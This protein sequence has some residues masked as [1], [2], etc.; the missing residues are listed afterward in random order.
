MESQLQRYARRLVEEQL[1]HS[2]LQLA[3][4]AD[5]ISTV[6]T[7]QDTKFGDDQK[8]HL[9]RYKIRLFGIHGADVEERALPWAY[10]KNST[11][12]LRG[13][14]TGTVTYPRGTFVYVTQDLQSNEYFIERVA[15]NTVKDLPL[16]AEQAYTPLSGFDPTNTLYPVPDTNFLDGAL[17]PG[18]EEYNVSFRSYMDYLQNSPRDEAKWQFPVLDGAKNTVGGMSSAI[19][20][21]IKDVERLKKNLIGSN[22][23]LRQSL[24]TLENAEKSVEAI[25]QA[26]SKQVKLISGYINT[27]M[28]KVQ[29][30]F[31]RKLNTAMNMVTANFPLSG[32]FA[33]NKLI[34]QAIKALS[35]AFNLSISEM[36]NLVG[37]GL[38]SVINKVVNTASC[39]IEN[40]VSNF[41]GQIVGQLSALINGVIGTISNVLGGAT[42]IL[43]SIG[44]VLGSIMD[45]LNCEVS[46]SQD[47]PVVK[48]WNFLDGGSPVKITLN[49]N[50]IFD[51]AK[52]IGEKFQKLTKVPKNISKY[53]FKFDPKEAVS[54]TLDQCDT[55]PIECGVPQVSFWGGTG[56]GAKANVA[57]S[58]TTG[59]VAHVDM[60]ESGSYTQAPYVSIVDI[61]GKGR[62]AVGKAILGPVETETTTFTSDFAGTIVSGTNYISG[63]NLLPDAPIQN[64]ID[65]VG[66]SIMQLSNSPSIPAG[67]KIIDVKGDKIILNK[68]IEGDGSV[69]DMQFHIIGFDPEEAVGITTFTVAVKKTPRTNKFVID[70]RQQR[71]VT[72]ERG[73]T[74]KFDQSRPSNGL[75]LEGGI[76]E[77]VLMKGED[78]FGEIS[79]GEYEEI[80]RHPLRFST[81]SD[82]I[83]NCDRSTEDAGPEDWLL[84]SS[85]ESMPAD[86]WV[87]TASD[88]WSPFLQAYGVYPEYEVLPGVHTGNWEIIL[89]EPGTYRVQ[90]QAD[91]LG[92]VSWNGIYLG[93]TDPIPT[94]IKTS[95]IFN[96]VPPVQQ[97]LNIVKLNKANIPVSQVIKE[98][99]KKLFLKD[100]DGNDANATFSIDSGDAIF[101]VKSTDPTQ[102]EI[103]G[104]GTVTLTLNWGDNPNIAGVALESITIGGTAWYQNG[105]SGRQ[106]ETIKLTE[107]EAGSYSEIT[108]SYKDLSRGPHNTPKYFEFEVF[109]K[110]KKHILTATI[111]NT[112]L[113]E[114]TNLEARRLDWE[115]NPGALAWEVTNIDGS[116]AYA[117]STQP[118]AEDPEAELTNCGTEYTQGITVF[119]VPGA[120]NAYI[121]FA[122]FPDAPDTLYYYCENHPKMGAKINIVDG[123]DEVD[124]D[125]GCR[126]ATLRVESLNEAGDVTLLSSLRGGSGYAAGA[127]NMLTVGGNGTS[128][129]INIMTVGDRGDIGLIQIANGGKNYQVGDI[130]TPVCN[131][132]TKVVKKEGIGVVR[133][134]L[135]STGYGY[136]PWP[137]GSKGGMERTWADRCQTI[138]HRDNGDWD[139]PYTTGEIIELYPGDCITL[140][141]KE[142]IC[143]DEDFDITKLPGS[144]LIGEVVTPRDMSDFPLSEYVE[145]EGDEINYEQTEK[146]EPELYVEPQFIPINIEYIGLNIT[147]INLTVTNNR[148]KILLRDGDGLDTNASFEIEEVNGGIAKFA[149]DGR[150]IVVQGA[151]VDVQ[152]AL[153]WKDD[154]DTAG[155]AIESI[156]IVGLNGP[157][158]WVRTGLRGI[159]RH[160]VFLSGDAK[161]TYVERVDGS[162]PDFPAGIAQWWF[163]MNGRYEGTF[164]QENLSQVPQLV[165]RSEKLIYRIGEYKEKRVISLTVDPKEWYRMVDV[166][167]PDN[168]CLTH[169]AGWSPFLKNYGVWP[170]KTETFDDI[171]Q[172]GTWE[173]LIKDAGNYYFEVQSDGQASINFNGR[174]LG[175]TSMFKSHNRSSFFEIEIK[176]DSLNKDDSYIP[177]PTP[178]TVEGTIINGRRNIGDPIEINPG[179]IAWVLRKGQA[180]LPAE[181]ITNTSFVDRDIVESQHNI[182]IIN[183]Y[184]PDSIRWINSKRIEFDE[185]PFYN[186]PGGW[187]INAI[188]TIDRVEG[189]TAVFNSNGKTIDCTGNSVTVTLTL[190][191]DDKRASDGFALDGIEI[192]T[193]RWNRSGLQGSDTKTVTLEGTV[194]GTEKIEIRNQFYPPDVTGTGDI[195]RSSLDPFQS[196]VEETESYTKSYYAINKYKIL[197]DG[198]DPEVPEIFGCEPDYT[199]AKL[200]GYSDCDIRHLIESLGIAVDQCM[201]NKLDDENWGKCAAFSVRLTAPDCP[202]KVIDSCPPGYYY[203]N[204]RCIRDTV[205]PG[206]C[207]PGYRKD[208]NGTCIPDGVTCPE[209]SHLE[210]GV[211]VPG[212]EPV[213]PVGFHKD[214]YGNCVPDDDTCPT[215]YKKE[216]GL[217]VP[218]VPTTCPSSSTYKIILCLDQITVANPGFGYNCCDDTVV[219]EPSNGA[220]AVIEECDGGI[221]RVR[222]TKCGSGFTE[223]PDVYINTKTGFNAFLIPVLK[224]HREN[225]NEF[226]EGTVVTQIIDCVGNVGP[227][228]KTEVT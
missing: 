213:C 96:E 112:G 167:P 12:G 145:N 54:N 8:T 77:L 209:G 191:Y 95:R 170:S 147:N 220:E 227:N 39:L 223:L 165:R 53:K 155:V 150:S 65:L 110:G 33:N 86:S 117:N 182:N 208:S 185:D 136:L 17:V 66:R 4:I 195:I 203:S 228:A 70:D 210:N 57:I 87:L 56:S 108:A 148:T 32:K 103:E 175:S 121:S 76:D 153:V 79:T 219:I 129:S 160:L 221:I 177:L 205:D 93:A 151:Y 157:K 85:L 222:V 134:E 186:G 114:L 199:N 37:Q 137:D 188:F 159:E 164:I 181:L 166:L 63:F 60:E 161:G 41:V 119:G 23:A 35:C 21:A 218:I 72:L 141:A 24:E 216:N 36:P 154:P 91:N 123:L 26:L 15:P 131:L 30:K 88:G 176:E 64:N 138:V 113:D 90:I 3:Q 194:I 18:N 146:L 152:F 204:G 116:I 120:P 61:C 132:G 130:I 16:T 104:T 156:T 215:G 101:I 214:E 82:G 217:C 115:N 200:L 44:D 225:L 10:P 46:P 140:P 67:T 22:S 162:D 100:G 80:N 78:P 173:V 89:A 43:G 212:K 31:L 94:I 59:Q 81:K 174:F 122:V 139:V 211:C 126:N 29:K 27:I 48:E 62:G 144:Q 92:T 201:Q 28:A 50:N 128:L 149:P 75:I 109:E 84:S 187:D 226:P 158:T 178:F 20:N 13:E 183:L 180:P 2:K 142:E 52:V 71:V 69:G 98:N 11:S 55:G 196:T 125:M 1:G 73:K 34:N 207:P 102:L 9:I 168:W 40:F 192:G 189:G 135:S 197:D 14:S 68:K 106:T 198:I 202:E 133:V 193:T 206:E 184:T 19:E 58:V 124:E 169:P 45:L 74:Y 224:S 143:I 190:T 6:K 127:T 118:F 105:G 171:P 49:T 107:L 47:D 97:T 99:G 111:Q 172:I 51:K 83:H 163:Y 179:A 38:L 7:E 5:D 42:D 25:S